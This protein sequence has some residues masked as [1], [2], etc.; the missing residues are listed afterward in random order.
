LSTGDSTLFSKQTLGQFTNGFQ[1]NIPVSLS[2][3]AFKYFQFNTSM[4]YTE[5][6]YLQ[7]IRNGLENTM[8]GFESARDTG[9]GFRR[10]YDYS[11]CSGWS[12]KRHG[13]CPRTG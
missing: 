9:W 4:N 6:W 5:R 8:N 13:M 11:F 2:L 12:T 3:Q 10:A 7:T 1:H